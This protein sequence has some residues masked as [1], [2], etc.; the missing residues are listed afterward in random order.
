MHLSRLIFDDRPCKALTGLS[1]G[2]LRRLAEEFAVNLQAYRGSRNPHRQ[3]KMGGGRRGHLPTALEKLVAILVYLKV[4]PTFDLMAVLFGASRTRCCCWVK[5]FLPVLEQPLGRRLD[6]PKRQIRSMEEFLRL[7][8]E[9][10]DVFIDG[11]ERPVQRPKEAKRRRKLYS[12]KKKT[13]TRKTLVTSDENRRILALSPTKSGRRHDNKLADKADIG[14]TL[15]PDVT[16]W[17]DTGFIGM[18]ATHPNIQIPKK[19]SKHNPLTIQDKGNNR[20]ISSIRVLS[21]HAICGIKRMKAASD[22]YRNKRPNLDDIFMLVSAGLWNYHL[23]M[24]T[25]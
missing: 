7:F 1:V 20:V 9:V 21:E 17:V 23:K 12:G 4:Y 22:I 19:R 3:R 15:P 6:L 8:P 10:K 24:A 5:Q 18:Q 25:T 16:A 11:T 13:P 2:E 14:G